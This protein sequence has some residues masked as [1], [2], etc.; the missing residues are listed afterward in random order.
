[1]NSIK[2]RLRHII[3]NVKQCGVTESICADIRD[4]LYSTGGVPGIAVTLNKGN[5]L[6]RTRMGRGYKS[7]KELTYRS[8]NANTKMMRATLPGETA[9]YCCISDDAQL[10]D[11]VRMICLAECSSLARAGKDSYGR[12]QLTTSLWLLKDNIRVLSFITDETFLDNKDNKMLNMFREQYAST[13]SRLTSEQFSLIRLIN[14]EFTKVVSEGN[15][16]EYLLTANLVHDAL[17]T[18]IDVTRKPFD[19]VVYPSV[20]TEGRW[21]LDMALRPDVADKKL[22]LMK[23]GVQTFYKNGE[24]SLLAIDSVW[25]YNFHKIGGPQ[26]TEE[27]ICTQLNLKSVKQLPIVKH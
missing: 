22:Q 2:T 26:A 21:G 7:A 1:M 24:I 17:Y 19:A 10:F 11:K 14:E 3:E 8:A 12:E 5:V 13:K 15:N 16:E 27:E 25:D 4:L 18:L 23:V 9:F 20:Q 6:H